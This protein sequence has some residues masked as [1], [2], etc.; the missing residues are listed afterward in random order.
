M[1]FDLSEEATGNL[2]ASNREHLQSSLPASE[3]LLGTE[4]SLG[5]DYSNKFAAECEAVFSPIKMSVTI[6]TADVTS[7]SDVSEMD[8]RDDES[9]V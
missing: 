6:P 1:E 8:L 2:H 4:R 7:G 5:V 3:R 9:A